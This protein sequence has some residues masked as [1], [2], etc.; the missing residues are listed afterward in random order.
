MAKTLTNANSALAIAIQGL[1]PVPQLIQGYSTDDAFMA[2]DVAPVETQMGVDGYLSAGFVP[3]STALDITLQADSLSND[4]FDNWMNAMSAA[5]EVYVA[6][7]TI[8]LPGVQGKWA[9]TKGFLTSGTPFPAGKKIL[10]PRKFTITF[11]SV[12]KANQ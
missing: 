2:G 9:M 5:R 6:N 8:I 4:V 3:Y 10:Q 7:A 11:E 1:Y 12:T